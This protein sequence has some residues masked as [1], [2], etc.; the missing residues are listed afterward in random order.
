MSCD[1]D[2][3]VLFCPCTVPGL[4]YGLFSNLL[5]LCSAEL[6]NLGEHSEPHLAGGQGGAARLLLR[7]HPQELLPRAEGGRE[8]EGGP[9]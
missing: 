3:N 4:N 2:E 1:Y 6:A 5:E 8:R 7:Q 9:L